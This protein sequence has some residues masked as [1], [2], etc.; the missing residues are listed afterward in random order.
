MKQ[1]YKIL[2]IFFSLF[3]CG[4]N[5][6][7]QFI[8]AQDT[9]R[10]Y[11]DFCPRLGDWANKIEVP[12]G[13]VFYMYPPDLDIDPWRY[14]DLYTAPE[15]IRSGYIRGT[16][17][18]RVDDYDIV[19]VEK[20][21]S[22]GTVSFKSDDVKVNIAV[23]LISSKDISIRKD[24]V[25]DKYTVNNKPVKGIVKGQS[26]KLKY[27]SITVSIKGH[28]IVFPKS[29]YEY[30]LNPEIDNMVVYYNSQKQTVYISANNGSPEA[31]YNAL[32]I[33]PFKGK[34]DVCIFDPAIK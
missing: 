31:P 30:L 22:H 4:L 3:L 7:A 11:I 15:K 14:V 21:S 16:D 26:P 9:V 12:N 27:Q 20:L 18:M 28:N 25:N 13:S 5:I 10:G 17:L 24:P 1:T 34:V 19:E 23:S 32:W 8:V 29:V 33:V 2:A 6:S